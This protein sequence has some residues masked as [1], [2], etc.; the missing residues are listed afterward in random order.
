MQITLECPQA[1]PHLLG[2]QIPK[3][4][5]SDLFVYIYVGPETEATEKMTAASKNSIIKVP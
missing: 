3:L 5:Y 4:V 2:A 1:L